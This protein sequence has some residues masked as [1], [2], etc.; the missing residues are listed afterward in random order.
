[1]NDEVAATQR[2]DAGLEQYSWPPA[3]VADVASL[4]VAAQDVVVD[5]ETVVR[6]TATEVHPDADAI[7]ATVGKAEKRLLACSAAVRKDLGLPPASAP[8]AIA[9]R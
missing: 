8:A 9:T 5:D 1:M 7:D 6:F 3:A 2:F 4:S